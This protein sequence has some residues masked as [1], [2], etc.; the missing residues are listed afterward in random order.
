MTTG[1]AL[2]EPM[3]TINQD[4]AEKEAEGEEDFLCPRQHAVASGDRREKPNSAQR[5]IWPG[6]FTFLALTNL[7]PQK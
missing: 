6:H 4:F 7:G 5:N 3:K 1:W 2:E